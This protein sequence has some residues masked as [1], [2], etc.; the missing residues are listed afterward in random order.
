MSQTSLTQSGTTQ[1]SMPK[2]RIRILL[3]ENIH[4]SALALLAKHGYTN[5]E[6]H[7]GALDGDA[8][9]KVLAETHVIGIRSRTKL[10][11]EIL[12]AAP[13]LMAIGCFCI[14]TNQV[15][16]DTAK[17]LGI[18]V[19]NAPYSNTRSVAELVLGEIIMLMRRIFPRS[20]AVHQGQWPKTA[21][22]SHEVR[23]KTLGIV[24]Y[25]H[26][27][28][29][30]S[31]LAEGVGMA[32][33]YVD[34]ID[35]LALGNAEPAGSLTELL[36]MSDVVSLHVPA[37]T[38]T[39]GM[40]GAAEIAAMKPGAMLV[41][42]S[43]GNVVD[44]D[45][46]AAAL[47]SGHVAGAAVDVFPEEPASTADEF[48]SPLRGLENVIL[49]PHIG[50]STIEAQAG[51]GSEVADKLVRYSDNGSTTGAVNFV[52]VA[53]PSQDR[54]TRF[55]HIHRNVPGVLGEINRIFAAR[56]TNI[57]GQYLRTDG[58]IGYVVVDV[59]AALEVGMGVRRAL[60]AIEGTIRVRF[61]L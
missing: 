14:G 26:I 40:I 55:M 51:I 36:S 52:E 15:D 33:R 30:L 41:N 6:R 25:G 42:A 13:K 59:D 12:E 23:G 57:L 18:P 46:L 22:G 19:F 32:V 20:N 47:R 54:G 7:K 38:A 8:L 50:G 11:K 21:E 45:A 2:D 48:Q 10:T 60:E 3:L 27:G 56:G 58:E 44:I 17:R 37:T 29:Q 34:V 28:K 16:T 9:R 35:T 53:L 31:V 4:D 39:K 1:L 61:L 43:R 5:V 49:T 24:G